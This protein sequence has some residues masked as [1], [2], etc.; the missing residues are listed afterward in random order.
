MILDIEEIIDDENLIDTW[1]VYQSEN[2]LDRYY[3]LKTLLWEKSFDPKQLVKTYNLQHSTFFEIISN[4]YNGKKN[5]ANL[6]KCIC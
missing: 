3:S 4:K 2:N 1:V 6:I 5:L